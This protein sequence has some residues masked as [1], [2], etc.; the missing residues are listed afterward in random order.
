MSFVFVLISTHIVPNEMPCTPPTLSPQPGRPRNPLQDIKTILLRNSERI[1]YSTNKGPA[2]VAAL[3][4]LLKCAEM[5]YKCC[6]VEDCTHA[7]YSR[8]T[9][10]ATS[11]STVVTNNTTS[12][13]DGGDNQCCSSSMKTT[14]LE[15]GGEESAHSNQDNQRT[16]ASDSKSENNP[17]M[18]GSFS[19]DVDVDLGVAEDGFNE[20]TASSDDSF[21]TA[22]EGYDV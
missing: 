14:D 4:S 6:F 17:A 7:S 22:D 2:I 12:M 11:G 21:M 8:T 13:N 19:S 18:S 10:A 9:N 20:W 16:A 3:H 5:R 15:V 1:N